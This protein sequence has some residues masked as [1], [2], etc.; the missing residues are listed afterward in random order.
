MLK[1]VTQ[2]LNLKALNSAEEL[3]LEKKAVV[4]IQKN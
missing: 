1:Y 4:P 2:S 3:W